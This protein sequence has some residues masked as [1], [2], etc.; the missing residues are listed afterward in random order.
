MFD[1]PNVIAKYT[2]SKPIGKDGRFMISNTKDF[3]DRGCLLHPLEVV[4]CSAVQR[5]RN[6]T[7]YFWFKVKLLLNWKSGIVSG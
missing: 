4:K 7:A 6:V 1:D 5:F 2:D 3:A